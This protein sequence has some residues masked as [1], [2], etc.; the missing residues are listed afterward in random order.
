MDLKQALLIIDQELD[1]YNFLSSGN[2]GLDHKGNL[3]LIDYGM[4]KTLYEKKWVPLA[5]AGV[6]PQISFKICQSCGNEKKIH[7]YGKDDTDRKCIAWG[8]E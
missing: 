8:K 5:E 6:L 2:Y 4:T 3:V 7:T 1:G